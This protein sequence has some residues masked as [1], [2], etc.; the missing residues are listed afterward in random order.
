MKKLRNHENGPDHKKAAFLWIINIFKKHK[1]SF[2][3]SGGLAARAYGSTRALRD[4]DFDIQN[5]AFEKI[6]PDVSKYVVNGPTR[7]ESRAFKNTLLKINY[8]GVNIDIA[9]AEDAEI[10]DQEQEKWMPDT[11]DL[12]HCEKKNIYGITVPVMS[13]QDLIAYKSKS[14][15]AEDEEDTSAIARHLAQDENKY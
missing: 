10:Y 1:I 6:L 7:N 11:T 5:S 14:P 3:V 15:R 13:P 8:M 4:I 12:E 9:G 2:V